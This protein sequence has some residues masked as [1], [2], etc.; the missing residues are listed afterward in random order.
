MTNTRAEPASETVWRHMLVAK[1]TG[2]VDDGNTAI[3]HGVY[4]ARVGRKHRTKLNN[5]ASAELG[6]LYHVNGW[7]GTRTPTSPQ[8]P[9]LHVA[10]EY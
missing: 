7:G 1:C 6:W 2:L 8:R 9:L 3:A 5:G 4:V 10:G